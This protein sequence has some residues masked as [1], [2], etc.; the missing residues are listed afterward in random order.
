MSLTDQISHY[1]PSLPRL[2]FSDNDYGHD[3]FLGVQKLFT[4]LHMEPAR[5]QAKTGHA[6]I[7]SERFF[8]LAADGFA[9]L[10][11]LGPQALKLEMVLADGYAWMD[12]VKLGAASRKDGFPNSYDR[13]HASNVPDYV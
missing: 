3:P 5:P 11:K 7:W 2:D 1:S 6:Y 9:Q 13:I 8:G 12:R 10:R 4:D